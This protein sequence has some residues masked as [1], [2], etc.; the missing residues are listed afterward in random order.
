MRADIPAAHERWMRAALDAA[1]RAGEAGEIPVGAALVRAGEAIAIAG[2]EREALGDPTAHAEMLV[3]REAARRL[4]TRRLSG[5]TLYVTLE[6]CPMCAGAIVLARPDAVVFGAHDARA[7]CCGS[8]YRL[9]EDTAL[10]LGMVP[11][12]GG[13]LAAECAAILEAFFQ[14]RRGP[15]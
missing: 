3:L 11:A 7:G 8:V 10:G 1:A 9:T 4:G 13:V 2:N 6:P 12:H 5:C 14:A 15:L